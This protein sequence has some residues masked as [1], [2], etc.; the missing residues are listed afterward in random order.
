MPV[1]RRSGCF[2][3]MKIK[4]S[5]DD[6]K[7]RSGFIRSVGVLV[8]GTAFAHGITALALPVLTRLYSPAD[9]NALA[10]FS[11]LLAIISVAA[12]LRFDIA[13]PIPETDHDAIN[14]LGLA[15][16][17][18]ALVSAMLVV[19]VLLGKQQIAVS[20]NQPVLAAYLWLLPIG[21][22]LAASYSA[23]QS[24]F[25]RKKQFGLIARSRVGQSAMSA[26]VQT[27]MG[28]AGVAPFG[29]LLGYIMNTSAACVVLGYRLLRVDLNRLRT[30]TRA[31]MRAMFVAYIRFPKYSTLEALS[32]SAALQ[33]PIIMIAAFGIGPEAGYLTLAMYV[34]QAPM[35]LVGNAIGQVYLSRAPEEYHTGRMAAFTTDIFS[36]LLKAGV[37]PLIFAGIVSPVAFAIIFGDEWRR[38]GLL[39]SWMTPWFVMQ[40]LATPISMALHVTG[41]QR[42][43]LALQVFGLVTRITAVWGAAM[44]AE[45]LISEAYAMSGFV[46]YLVYVVVLLRIV[47]AEGTAIK[48]G[49]LKCLPYVSMWILAGG[50]VALLIHSIYTAI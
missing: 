34:M 23:L 17:S 45:S 37:G 35:S 28:L 36:A 50:G 27:G 12:C 8:G 19:L 1:M 14:V 42:A 32:N 11:G 43:A 3:T 18:A 4:S 41:N 30:I 20:L 16:T 21:V 13:V 6:G 31:H 49:V 9:F 24:W 7:P 26:G 33:V 22:F 46:F 39:V 44:F 10:A 29:L 38:A 5:L 40:F 15:I 2:R 47:A 25:V 48:S